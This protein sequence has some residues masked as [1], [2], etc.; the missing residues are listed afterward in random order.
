[1]VF[2]GGTGGGE[3]SVY[4]GCARYSFSARINRLLAPTKRKLRRETWRVEFFLSP[5]LQ[6][7]AFL[8]SSDQSIA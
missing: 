7:L 5:S 3:C 2:G 6:N 4:L 1:M 8:P